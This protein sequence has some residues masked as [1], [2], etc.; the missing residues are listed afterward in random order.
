MLES[1]IVFFMS[2]TARLI[3]LC[4]FEPNSPE[5]LEEAI[6]VGVAK[7]IRGT[8]VLGPQS[9]ERLQ[10]L[11]SLADA[12]QSDLIELIDS[13]A[14]EPIGRWHVIRHSDVVQLKGLFHLHASSPDELMTMVQVGK[15]DVL[16]DGRVWNQAWFLQGQLFAGHPERIEYVRT[17]GEYFD[18]VDSFGS[19]FAVDKSVAARAVADRMLAF[20][21]QTSEHLHIDDILVEWKRRLAGLL[22]FVLAAGAADFSGARRSP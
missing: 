5:F 10:G 17:L 7:L 13:G 20:R 22:Q 19:P 12:T 14:A 4:H 3:G 2:S 18:I 15:S 8:W 9:T 6:R 16:G 1:I 11:F 21:G